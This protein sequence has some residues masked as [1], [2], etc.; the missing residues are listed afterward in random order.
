MQLL[1]EIIEAEGYADKD[2][3]KDIHRGFDLAG[4]CPASGVL[5]GKLVPVTLQERELQCCA[6]KMQAS[7]PQ[8]FL[9]VLQVIAPR[10][11]SY[12]ERPWR[13]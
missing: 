2:L 5:P 4:N 6:R 13:K 12:G 7:F 1:R 10:T 9:W 3:G 8:G 11:W